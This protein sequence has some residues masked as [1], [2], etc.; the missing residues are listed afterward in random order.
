MLK[1]KIRDKIIF[2]VLFFLLFTTIFSWFLVYTYSDKSLKIFFYDVGQGDAIHI[3]NNKNQDI[4]IDGGPDNVILSKL[5]QNM[6]FY[7]QKIELMI[8]THPHA[9]H[10]AG[11]IHILNKYQVEQIVYSDVL[12]S[13]DFFQEWKRI[14][15][16][17]NIPTREAKIGQ[18]IKLENSLMYVLLP[19]TSYKD[20]KV[21]N[22]N[23][24]SIVLKLVNGQISYL[25]TGDIEKESEVEL[26]DNMGNKTYGKE[27]KNI[28]NSDV[29]KVAHHGSK[30]S[31]SQELVSLI[32]PKYAIISVGKNNKFGHPNSETVEKLNNLKANILR[33]DKD[34]D[35]KCISDG[36]K[37]ECN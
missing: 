24:T 33:T 30:S 35:I 16:E 31:S 3:R 20:K 32:N 37:I 29:L 25:F 13:T 4:L 17:K 9:D 5:G 27:K 7:D 21:E 1:L 12:D 23:S 22:L 14:I 2:S 6:P 15:K 19:K 8:L 26:M 36:I 11:L 28:L 18:T 10:I 34:S